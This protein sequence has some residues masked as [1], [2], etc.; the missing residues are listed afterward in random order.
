[1]NRGQFALTLSARPKAILPA[2]GRRLA[3]LGIGYVLEGDGA[4][5]V[6]AGEHGRVLPLYEYPDIRRGHGRRAGRGRRRVRRRLIG[7]RC[8]ASWPCAV[9]GGEKGALLGRRRTIEGCLGVCCSRLRHATDDMVR[10]GLANVPDISGESCQGSARSST[11]TN[12]A[13]A[14]RLTS[15]ASRSMSLSQPRS[16][17]WVG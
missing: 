9:L 10:T 6:F 7:C 5:D 8:P 4:L 3:A 14:G 15:L 11:S 17:L 16:C 2:R 13:P 12:D 1:M